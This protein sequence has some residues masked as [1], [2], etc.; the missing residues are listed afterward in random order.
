VKDPAFL[1]SVAITAPLRDMAMLDWLE[2]IAIVGTKEGRDWV[3]PTTLVKF[4]TMGYMKKLAGRDTEL[5]KQLQLY[6][7]EGVNVSGHW[8]LNEADR[9]QDLIDNRLVLT[10]EKEALV[11]GLIKKMRTS[12]QKIA[13]VVLPKNYVKVPKGRKYGMLSG[14]AVRKEI[15]QDIWGS[16]SQGSFDV[17]DT[18][19]IS[20]SWAEKVLGTGGAFERYNRLWKWSKVSANP[21]SWVRNFVS[22]MIF[23]TLGP[24][25]IHK[26]PFLFKDAIGDQLKA[27]Y[28]QSKGLP[29]DPKSMTVL[30]DKM[31]L[32]SGGFSQVE[33]KMIRNSFAESQVKGDGVLGILNV[34]NAFIGF[35]KY[36]QRPTSDLYGG[37]DTLGKVMMLTHLKKKGYSDDRAAMEAEKW[38][39]DYSNPLPSVKYL[40]KSAFGA[41]F[42]SYPSFVAPLMIETIIKRPWKLAPYFIF[43]ELMTALFKEQQDIDDEEWQAS[44][45]TLPTYL[46]NKAVGGA[47]TD[48]LFPKSVIPLVWPASWGGSLDKLG[49]AQPIDIGY[50]QP[51][52]MFAEVMRELDPTKKGGW[53]P[54]D[55]TH[56]IGLLGAPIL[57]I[58]TTMLTNRDP[59]SDREI[60]DEFATQGEKAAAWFHYMFNLTMPPMMHGWTAGPG[61]GFGAI[62]RLIDAFDDTVVTKEGEPKFTEGQAVARMFGM[63]VTPIA[64]HEARQ[65]IAYFEMQKIQ[66]LQRKIVHDY[67]SGVFQG[68]SKE[69]LKEVVKKNV[70]KLNALV[71]DLKEMLAKPLPASLKRSKM[72]KLKAREKFLQRVKQLK[73]G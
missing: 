59:F 66:R 22:N 63:N 41:P 27:R 50:L 46:K 60:F 11:K 47:I 14:M 13:G 5:I 49:R 55:A 64:P 51:W 25:P 72:Q 23:M 40:R 56:S 68:L 26:L 6:D 69:E 9:L 4:D 2:Q 8:L 45:E 65:K 71:K 48:K 42:L 15:F 38:L 24:I 29:P 54:A 43:G 17:D 12:G 35:E 18:G 28:R 7:T 3:L 39:F 58:A 19:H 34:R 1:S 44:L 67:K 62:R 61:Q 16:P 52:G 30:A 32:T 37:I 73:A 57:N 10:P 53:S 31:G 33:L 20:Q 36:V 21:P 70:D